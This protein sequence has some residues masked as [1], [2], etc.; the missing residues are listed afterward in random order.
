MD[1]SIQFILNILE[2]KI[3]LGFFE[4]HRPMIERQIM[5]RV[6]ATESAHFSEYS[7]HLQ[8]N[9]KEVICLLDVLTILVSQFFRDPLVFEYIGALILPELILKKSEMENNSLRIWSAGC[10]RGEEA[11]SMGILIKE[12][13]KKVNSDLSVN[14]FATDINKKALVQSQEAIYSHESVNDVKYGWLKKYFVINGDSFHLKPEIQNLVNMSFYNLLDTKSYAPPES[15]YGNFDMI[16]CRNVLIYIQK[17]SQNRIF[18]K[19]YRSLAEG[20]YLVLGNAETPTE[21][22]QRYFHKV[23]EGCK[24]YQKHG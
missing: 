7:N 14:I 20:G 3:G 23:H 8:K 12:L 1:A 10:S 21:K 16:L 17:E 19:F 11:Y 5:Q 4:Y 24:I 15:I 2:K 18:E 9:E 13:V 22:F 6:E